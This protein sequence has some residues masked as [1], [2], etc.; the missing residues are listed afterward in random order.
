MEYVGGRLNKH[1]SG[2]QTA[3]ARNFL[4]P[5]RA[6]VAPLPVPVKEIT[7]DGDKM[8]KDGRTYD[9]M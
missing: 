3:A 4:R 7:R 1:E 9:K 2:P 6:K 5:L 8:Y